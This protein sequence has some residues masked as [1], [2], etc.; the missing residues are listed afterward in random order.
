MKFFRILPWFSVFHISQTLSRL[1]T[2]PCIYPPNVVLP[3][4]FVG[5]WELVEPHHSKRLLVEFQR[6]VIKYHDN[7]LSVDLLNVFTKH[8]FSAIVQLTHAFEGRTFRCTILS[9]YTT[10]VVYT[11]ETPIILG[12]FAPPGVTAR[13]LVPRAEGETAVHCLNPNEKIPVPYLVILW[14]AVKPN[15]A[16]SVLY[17]FQGGRVLTKDSSVTVDEERAVRYQDASAIFKKG[18]LLTDGT[19]VRCSF[20]S[21]KSNSLI[22]SKDFILTFPRNYVTTSPITFRFTASPAVTTN[23]PIA[24]P[25]VSAVSEQ[26]IQRGALL[27]YGK[28]NDWIPLLCRT[29]RTGKR[30]VRARWRFKDEEGAYE[31]VAEFPTVPSRAYPY[32]A[33]LTAQVAQGLFDLYVMVSEV[34]ENKV[35]ECDIWDASNSTIGAARTTV[36]VG[37]PPAPAPSYADPL[38]TYTKDARG[39]VGSKLYMPCRP[40]G[41]LKEPI[42]VEWVRKAVDG[43]RTFPLTWLKGSAPVTPFPGYQISNQLDQNVFDLTITDL[44]VKNNRDLYT[45]RFYD[46][47]G[48]QSFL[49]YEV[50]VSVAEPAVVARA[51]T[52]TSPQVMERIVAPEVR[53][54]T[55]N[56]VFFLG[57]HYECFPLDRDVRR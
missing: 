35:M 16:I 50:T 5:L 43:S 41:A 34:S 8:D 51:M 44:T 48:S 56:A 6:G 45:C 15:G 54:E 26:V 7:R 53:I 57:R 2:L 55:S 4:Y 30:A 36:V 25:T 28:R 3:E 21:S 52:E 12:T 10:S 18:S 38:N 37:K 46:A 22:F 23:L 24:T 19:R 17:D 49:D 9:S 32:W 11:Q 14:L 33:F 1:I 40:F 31:D 13:P 27:K 42:K 39:T 20:A 29:E 47:S